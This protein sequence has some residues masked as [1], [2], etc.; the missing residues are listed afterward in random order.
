MGEEL[1]VW[2]IAGVE[3]HRDKEVRLKAAAVV[4]VVCA[5]ATAPRKET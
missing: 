4:A 2:R 3:N 5:G 1:L